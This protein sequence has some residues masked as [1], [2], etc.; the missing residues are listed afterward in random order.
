VP[1]QL[2]KQVLDRPDVVSLYQHHAPETCP[3]VYSIEDV[4][5]LPAKIKTQF[6]LCYIKQ[7]G[8]FSLLNNNRQ[9]NLSHARQ[10]YSQ[11]QKTIDQ[12]ID[13]GIVISGPPIKKQTLAEKMKIVKNFD[14]LLEIYNQW[15]DSNPDISTKI[16]ADA[17]S[18]NIQKENQF[19]TGTSNALIDC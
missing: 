17:M 6:A 11:A 1:N 15:A 7:E 4:N 14:Q 3:A 13:L 16:S 2:I 12:M 9:E 5:H 18:N 10:G 8:I 19:W